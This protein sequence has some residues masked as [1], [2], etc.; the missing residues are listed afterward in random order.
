ML[1]FI[2][3]IIGSQPQLWVTNVFTEKIKYKEKRSFLY[4]SL[5]G[6]PQTLKGWATLAWI[7]ST[8]SCRPNLRAL[9]KSIKKILEIR[10]ELKLI[11]QYLA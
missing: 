1:Y 9:N 11:C 7:F 6:S 5:K 3:W 4:H 10:T 2:V 8:S